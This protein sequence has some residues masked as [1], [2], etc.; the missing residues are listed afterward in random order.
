MLISIITPIYNEEEILSQNSHFF[1]NLSKQTELIFVDGGSTDRS[2]EIAAYYGKVLQAQKG[3]A[4]QMNCGARVAQGDILFFLHADNF[5]SQETLKT[6]KDRMSEGTLIGGCLS[7]RIDKKGIVYRFLEMHGNI[8]AKMSKI[9]YGDQGIFVEKKVFF[10]IGG[11]PEVP[12]MEDVL[13]TKALRKKGATAVLRDAIMASARRWEKHGLLQTV[14][15]HNVITILFMVGV[16]LHR[17]KRLYADL[18]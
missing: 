4:T 1:S 17:I 16:P 12:I 15:I 10:E 11:F 2:V 5:I 6:I 7:Q 14:F 13:F 3:R 9:F 8:R 18:R